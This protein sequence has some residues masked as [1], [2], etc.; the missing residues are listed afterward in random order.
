MVDAQG[1]DGTLFNRATGGVKDL[2]S[3]GFG[4]RG[5]PHRALAARVGVSTNDICIACKNRTT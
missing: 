3:G 2:H 1:D 5:N 4:A